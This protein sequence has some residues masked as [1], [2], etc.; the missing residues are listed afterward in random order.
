[1][2]HILTGN[3]AFH[4]GAFFV[5][6]IRNLTVFVRDFV[7]FNPVVFTCG[8][9]PGQRPAIT[10]PIPWW[11]IVNSLRP[12]Q[13]GRHFPEDIFKAIFVNEN[14]WLSIWISLKFV[15]RGLITNI[16]ALVQ[17]MAWRRPGDRPLSEQ[18]VVRYSTHICVMRLQWVH[19]T[20]RNIL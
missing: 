15:L 14:I 16:T 4:F 7:V 11:Y 12:R 9:C 20:L 10:W 18:T 5:T 3:K 13:N 2:R 8:V 19:C 17:I 1:M 6:D